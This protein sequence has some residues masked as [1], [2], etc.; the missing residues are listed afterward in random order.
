MYRV[1]ARRSTT[2][3]RAARHFA[4]AG[5]MASGALPGHFPKFQFFFQICSGRWEHWS[6]GPIGLCSPRLGVRRV[7]AAAGAIRSRRLGARECPAG[8]ALRLG[9]RGR[10]RVRGARQVIAQPPGPSRRCRRGQPPAGSPRR[11]R[12][13]PIRGQSGGPVQHV[14]QRASRGRLKSAFRGRPSG[15][16]SLVPGVR[17]P[18][19][20]MGFR[21][22]E[23][24]FAFYLALYYADVRW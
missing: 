21:C 3:V 14:V 5:A 1:A 15:C 11:P 23:G 10:G 7:S 16:R 6:M 24:R 8:G 4:L 9:A 20:P 2:P 12:P 17:F 22:N 13:R 19:P 18:P